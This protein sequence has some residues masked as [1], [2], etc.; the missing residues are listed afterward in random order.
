LKAGDLSQQESKNM[1]HTNMKVTTDKFSSEQ[2]AMES[3]QQRQTVT[4]SGIFNQEK[5]SSS[6]HSV[7]HTTT[8]KGIS[9]AGSSMLQ[10]TSFVFVQIRDV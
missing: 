2:T 4:S 3:Q 1:A 6:S 7:I 9:T 10:V 5:H 8:T